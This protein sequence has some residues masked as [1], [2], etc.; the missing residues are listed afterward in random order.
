[1]TVKEEKHFWLGQDLASSKALEL[2]VPPEDVQIEEVG[3]RVMWGPAIEPA[4]EGPPLA[5]LVEAPYEETGAAPVQEGG[6]T[7]DDDAAEE[8]ASLLASTGST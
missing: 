7:V 6:A 1:M 2:G 4:S 5:P 3:E 8:T